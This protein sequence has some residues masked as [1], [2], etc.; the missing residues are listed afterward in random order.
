[1]TCIKNLVS[2][3]AFYDGYAVFGV[4]TGRLTRYGLINQNGE[5]VIAPE[6]YMIHY[7]G[8]DT[9]IVWL[10]YSGAARYVDIMSGKQIKPK[11]SNPVGNGYYRVRVLGGRLGIIDREGNVVIKSKYKH[12]SWHK[13]Y[14]LA[15]KI[16]GK[17]G[18]LSEAGLE[19]IQFIYDDMQP[20]AWH[21]DIC[22]RSGHFNYIPVRQGEDW[23][24][25]DPT[26]HRFSR[27]RYD[28]L[29]PF[30]KNGLA[31]FGI[32]T[33]DEIRYGVIDKKETVIVPALYEYVHILSDRYI[34][35]GLETLAGPILAAVN[36]YH[37]PMFSML[38]TKMHYCDNDL[39]IVCR[40]DPAK[41]TDRG[42]YIIEN[43][44]VVHISAKA[45]VGKVA[46]NNES[47][48]NL[49]RQEVIPFEYRILYRRGNVFIGQVEKTKKWGVLS[50]TGEV[51]V[52]F[53]YDNMDCT[54]N[55]D[56]IAAEKN[57]EWFYIN[58]KNERVLL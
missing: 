40:P 4:K 30:S 24:Y 32:K 26:G 38:Y 3:E 25:I 36:I 1:M 51:V 34:M 31:V 6:Y 50:M 11:Y 19:S 17:W 53:E 12:L 27:N 39:F 2:L 48:C 8:G 7:R 23:F 33:S 10:T 44:G 28:F 37:E 5:I 29:D 54:D 49:E 55:T 21:S 22:P 52:P 15:Q 57:K 13:S 16:N 43:A 35:V 41:K 56:Y 14:Y 18:V 58:L 45:S 46:R 9:M 42:G 20:T 47:F